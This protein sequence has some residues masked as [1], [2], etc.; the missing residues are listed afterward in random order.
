MLYSAKILLYFGWGVATLGCLGHLAVT[1]FQCLG[2]QGV[3]TL[4]CIGLRRVFWL[5][6]GMTPRCMEPLTVV[7]NCL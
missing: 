4:Q 5:F 7:S 1:T 6:T 2:H 3:M